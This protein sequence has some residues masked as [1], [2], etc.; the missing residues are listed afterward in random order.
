M[1]R[2]CFNEH[3]FGRRCLFYSF[4]SCANKAT[5]ERQS[6]SCHHGCK[7]HGASTILKERRKLQWEPG[8]CL[9]LRHLGAAS[10]LNQASPEVHVTLGFKRVAFCKKCILG[11]DV[12]FAAS[13]QSGAEGAKELSCSLLWTAKDSAAC[14]STSARPN[15]VGTRP[16]K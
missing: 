9:L 5:M 12:A 14:H 16:V 2:E 11:L 13:P 1:S 3:I 6:S 4:C 8:R 7:R 15:R 10:Y